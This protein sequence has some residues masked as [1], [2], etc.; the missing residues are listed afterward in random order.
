V[1]SVE[2]FV[3]SFFLFSGG[4]VAKTFKHGRLGASSGK[5]PG[6]PLRAGFAISLAALLLAAGA[7]EASEKY[8]FRSKSTETK[9]EQAVKR[10][11]G[12]MQVVVS[13]SNQRLTLY[14]GGVPIAQSPVS[15]G[16]SGRPTPMGVFTVI[17][18]QKFHRSNLYD[19][20]PMPFMQRI[21]WSGVAMHAGM[22]PGYPASHGCIRM[23]AD[24][25]VR[26]YGLTKMGVRVIVTRNDAAPIEIAHP[27]LFLMKQPAD[28]PVA[29][30]PTDASRVAE[31][32]KTEQADIIATGTVTPAVAYTAYASVKTAEHSNPANA[33]DAANPADATIAKTKEPSRR[34]GPISVFISRKEGKLFVRQNAQPLFDLPVI[35]QNPAQPL[36]THVFT[37]MELNG[38]GT[39]MRWTVTSIPSDYRRKMAREDEPLRKRLLR[40]EHGKQSKASQ[41]KGPPPAPQLTAAQALDRID[42]P[43]D[44]IDR[45]SELVSPGSSLL[46]SDNG[47][48]EETGVDTDFVILTPEAVPQDERPRRRI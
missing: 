29:S 20:A 27:R 45:I 39:S 9:K 26:L 40:E 41:A 11:A 16:T 37:A 47:I 7:A 33:T 14:S 2:R 21:T 18:K 43:Q 48:S 8:T 46:I 34:N 10:P 6:A 44:V 42:L 23:P 32:V 25:A 30:R 4:V 31:T 38:D 24:F 35:I 36:G 28:L 3:H 1:V 22:L 19:D 13:I 5:A 15:T 17:Q 12:P